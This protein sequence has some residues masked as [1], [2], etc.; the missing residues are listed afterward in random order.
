MTRYLDTMPQPWTQNTIQ[1]AIFKN[2]T[3]ASDA[4]EETA[5]GQLWHS[6][7][8]LEE[9]VYVLEMNISDLLDEISLFSDRSKN[10]VFWHQVD[11]IKAER[12]TLEVKRKMANCTAALMALVEHARNFNR[13]S[14]VPNYEDELKRHFVPAGLHDFLQGLRNYCVHWRIAQVN[15]NMSFGEGKDSRTAHFLVTQAE[16]LA[17]DGWTS[18]AKDYISGIDGSIDLYEIFYAYRSNVQKFYAWHRGTV[19]CTYND[20]LQPYLEYKRLYKGISN[21]LNWNLLITS[22]PK[23]VNPLQYLSQYLPRH[24]VEL[25]LAHPHKSKEQADTIIRLLDMDEFC[26]DA[27]RAKVYGLFDV[28]E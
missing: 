6:L 4:I 27:F 9:S 22:A 21:K 26:D 16:L 8:E 25:V 2:F 28:E 19:L 17:W 12:H 15:W 3:D 1:T 7:Q 13:T 5:G 14:P 18:K 24:Q 10:P 23:G 11:G 20:K